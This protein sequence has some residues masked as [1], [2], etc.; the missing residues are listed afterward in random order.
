MAQERGAFQALKQNVLRALQLRIFV[1]PAQPDNVIETHTFTFFYTSGPQETRQ[2]RG[3]D[4][5]GPEGKLMSVKNAQCA[6]QSLMRQ[7][8]V[9]CFTLPR[10]PG[11][12]WRQT[13]RKLRT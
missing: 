5:N 11:M 7:M 10:L 6:M 2:F 13:I 8:V 12:L 9:Y 1:D 4:I 3:L